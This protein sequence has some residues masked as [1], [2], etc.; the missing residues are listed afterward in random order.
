[1]VMTHPNDMSKWDVIACQHGHTSHDTQTVSVNLGE[2]GYKDCAPVPERFRR[3]FEFEIWD[4]E[5]Y[6]D[7]PG[8]SESGYCP[9]R[10]VISQTIVSHRIWEPRETILTLAACEANPG[11]V[12]DLGCQLGWFSMLA[13]SAGCTVTAVDADR[14][15]LDRV[16]WSA[17]LNGWGDRVR[18]LQ[19]RIDDNLNPVVSG[20]LTFVK[21]DLEGAEIHAVNAL[22]PLIERREIQHMMIEISPVFD[23]YYPEMVHRI[24]D[25]GYIAHVL[26]PKDYPPWSMENVG[27]VMRRCRMMSHAVDDIALW[28]QE[29]VWFKLP[30]AEW[31]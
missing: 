24:I 16:D 1:M 29:D 4:F 22:W 13:A 31:A 17:A 12:L 8:E 27:D 2:H 20:P 26:P 18:T 25:A 19:T 11:L 15:C 28:H 21:M 14:M 6:M 23:D 10:D 30:E 7:L 5:K 9:A 3:S